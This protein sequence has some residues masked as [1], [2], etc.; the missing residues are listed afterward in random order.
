MSD[1]TSA[2]P[3]SGS[4]RF[5][6]VTTVLIA[7][8][9]TV[10]ALVASQAATASGN[11]TEAQHNGVIAKINLER[12]DGGSW[13]QIA[14]SRRA[15]DSY[16]FNRR[17]YDLTFEYVS[18]AEADGSTPEGTRLRL[19]AAG[20]LEESNLAYDFIDSGYLLRDASGELAEFDVDN[21]LNDQRQTAAIYQDVD[22]DDDFT[23][24]GQLRQQ[25][26]ALNISLL[27]WFVALLFFTWAELTRSWLRWIWLGAGVLVSLGILAAYALGGLSAALGVA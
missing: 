22:Y 6:T 16:R 2:K 10:I 26:L 9:S 14:R 18:R 21:Y 15:F 1:T 11:A 25:S 12:T 27:F 24:A 4:N 19:E 7:L 3:E 23:G 8:V 17:L 13:A 20:Q 5:S